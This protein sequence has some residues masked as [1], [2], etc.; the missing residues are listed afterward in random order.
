M[1][2]NDAKDHA[3]AE[4]VRRTG[5][6][7]DQ[8]GLWYH[9]LDGLRVAVT[10]IMENTLV[11]SHLND[12]AVQ[13]AIIGP[14]RVYSERFRHGRQPLTATPDF[15]ERLLIELREVET[16]HG[17]GE[18]EDAQRGIELPYLQLALEKI[19]KAAGGAESNVLDQDILERRSVRGILRDHLDEEMGKLKPV[20]ANG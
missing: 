1:S 11:L 9:L 3:D 15:V 13:E 16:S 19:W 12:T 17:R 10:D 6:H 4:D 5:A 8:S 20:Q 18:R 7:G 2:A 14:L